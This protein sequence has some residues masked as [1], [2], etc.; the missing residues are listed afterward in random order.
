MEKVFSCPYNVFARCVF[1]SR[2]SSRIRKFSE[3][4]TVESVNGNGCKEIVSIHFFLP[5]ITLKV[6]YSLST[7]ISNH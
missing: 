5:S 3:I 6:V 2:K 7:E 4:F 1:A